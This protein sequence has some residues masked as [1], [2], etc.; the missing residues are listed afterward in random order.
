M[1]LIFSLT[2]NPRAQ[3]DESHPSPR[4]CVR[5]LI[6]GGEEE[7]GRSSA[8]HK[9]HVL[10]LGRLNPPNQLAPVQLRDVLS[11]FLSPLPPSLDPIRNPAAVSVNACSS[12]SDSVLLLPL[13][14][15]AGGG[16]QAWYEALCGIVQLQL[17]VCW[18]L[19]SLRKETLGTL[20]AYETR[21]AV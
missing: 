13:H 6:T 9:A 18:D 1:S 11:S 2:V 15:L 8:V 21:K 7:E 14:R 4:C 16:L 17:D 19:L 3:C 5:V 20:I 12:D 10:T